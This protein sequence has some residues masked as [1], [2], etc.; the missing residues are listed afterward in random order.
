MLIVLW[1]RMDV[2]LVGGQPSIHTQI[3]ADVEKTHRCSMLTGTLV[4]YK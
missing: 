1:Q 2:K 4:L 3:P